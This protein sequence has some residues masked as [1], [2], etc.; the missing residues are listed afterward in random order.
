M[1]YATDGP[2]DPPMEHECFEHGWD[3]C[4]CMEEAEDRMFLDNWRDE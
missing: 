2:L 3:D 4:T 1:S